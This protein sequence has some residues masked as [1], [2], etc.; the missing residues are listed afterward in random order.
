MRISSSASNRNFGFPVSIGQSSW[1]SV[2]EIA[3]RLLLAALFLI[4]GLGKIGV[5]AGTVTY[6]SSAGV[7]GPL[8]PAVIAVE[9]LGALAIVLGRKTRIT[10]FILAGYSLLIAVIFHHNFADQIQAIQFLKNC[11]IAG[12]FFL[13]VANGAG[14]L[15]QDHRLSKHD[16]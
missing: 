10:A 3:G 7:L 14:P 4:S 9:V 1:C 13:L 6:M 11:S 5:Y 8:L 12:G 16:R 15:S 2:D